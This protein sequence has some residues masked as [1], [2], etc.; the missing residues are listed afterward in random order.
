ML[1]SSGMPRQDVDDRDRDREN[2]RE[3][4][5]PPPHSAPPT[6]V[7]YNGPPRMFRGRGRGGPYQ[8]GGDWGGKFPCEISA[9]ERHR[10]ACVVDEL[11]FCCVGGNL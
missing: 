8:P 6:G 1:H 11:R 5:G 9:L 3:R 10:L 2:E 4:I 7:Q